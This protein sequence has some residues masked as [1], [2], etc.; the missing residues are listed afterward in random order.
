MKEYN[1]FVKDK[2][3]RGDEIDLD[4]I[5]KYF[6]GQAVGDISISESFGKDL[7]EQSDEMTPPIP[8]YRQVQINHSDLVLSSADADSICSTIGG[9]AVYQDYADMLGNDY[10]QKGLNIYKVYSDSFYTFEFEYTLIDRPMPID[11]LRAF[12]QHNTQVFALSTNSPLHGLTM[13]DIS[14]LGWPH[15]H[16]KIIIRIEKSPKTSIRFF[17]NEHEVREWSAALSSSDIETF[18]FYENENIKFYQFEENEE[19]QLE[20]SVTDYSE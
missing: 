18:V 14:W 1:N 13:N 2:V 5:R 17:I 19:I 9:H 20:D 6:Q 16:Q 10:F 4:P 3:L 15:K 7:K 11:L 12:N 8:T